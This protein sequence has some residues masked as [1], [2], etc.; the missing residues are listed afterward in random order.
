MSAAAS[1]IGDIAGTHYADFQLIAHAAATATED[2]GS[3]I[4]PAAIKVTAIRICPSLAATGDN[5]NRTN[6]NF[7]NRT[8]GAGS[9]EVANHD[10]AT[11]T[12]AAKGTGVALTVTAFTMAANDALCVE[13]EKVA[14]GLALGTCAVRVS[15]QYV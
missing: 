15:F 8:S 5:T 14:S 6:Y 3:W 2:V 9:T 10:Y 4:A 13:A 1:G 7:I 11:G 12:D